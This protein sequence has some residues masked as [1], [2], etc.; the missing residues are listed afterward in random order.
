VL[1]YPSSP[2][3]RPYI[4]A[5]SPIHAVVTGAVDSVELTAQRVISLVLRD[6][7]EY[8][9]LPFPAVFDSSSG[10]S[11]SQSAPRHVSHVTLFMETMPRLVDL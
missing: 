3:L 4:D 2:H 6:V 9:T 1:T 7:A 8:A 11:M 5:L 10:S